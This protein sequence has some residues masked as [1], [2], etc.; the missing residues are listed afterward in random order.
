MYLL[1][2]E[3]ITD[4][5]APLLSIPTFRARLGNAT[6]S[7]VSRS[8]QGDGGSQGG[9]GNR[10]VDLTECEEVFLGKGQGRDL[11]FNVMV[12]PKTDAD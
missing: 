3:D 5:L 11:P 12:P 8:R 6:L 1:V 4:T 7:A 10:Y 9:E 2:A